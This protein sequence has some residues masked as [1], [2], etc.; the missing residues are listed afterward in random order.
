MI[1]NVLEFL[2]REGPKAENE[3]G[4]VVANCLTEKVVGVKR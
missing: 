3:V 1:R 2:C 4:V